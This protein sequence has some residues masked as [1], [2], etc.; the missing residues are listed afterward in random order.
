MRK[1]TGTFFALFFATGFLVAQNAVVKG[2]VVDSNSS[3][4]VP[5]VTITIQASIY[6][7]MTDA[8]GL[9][10]IES[11]EL[12]QGEQVLLVRKEGY[13]SQRIPITIQ[14]G[15]TLNLDPILLEIDLTDIEAQIGVISLSDNELSDDDGT[16]FNVS[17]LLQ[18]SR[19]AFLN[20]ASFDFSA[21]FF[22]PRGLDN[23][24]G[25]VLING[26]EM[27][28]QFTGR[29]QWGNWG[30]LNDVQRN[31]EFSMGL[32]AND[33]TFGDVAGTT[34]IVMRASQYRQGGRV[35]YAS[36]NRSYRGRIIGTY[37]SGLMQNGWAYSFSVARR[38]GDEGYQEGTVYDANSFFASV[39][40]KINDEHSLNF[41]AF[42][43]PNRRGRSTAIT[44]EQ[45]DLKG[46]QYNP[47][48]G[49][50]DGEIRN[51]RIREIE[52]P[53]FMLNHYWTLNEK[54]SLNTNIGYQTGTI[55]NSRIDN[56][57]TRL[58]STLD[59]Q[60]F[61][62]GGARNISGNYYQRL[63]SYFLRF[64]NPTSYNYQQAYLARE[65]FVAD[66]QIPWNTIYDANIDNDGNARNS[67]YI[68]QN[69]V[70]K[71]NQFQFNSILFS[72]ISENI[73]LNA[74]VAF[75]NL[76]SENYAEVSDLLGGNGY[77]DIDTFS[78]DASG[79][80]SATTTDDSFVQ[81]DV[82]NPNRIVGVGDRYKYNFELDATT[83]SG[84]AQAQF[85]YSL[86]DFYA[87]VN[88]G[89]TSYQRNGLY[90]NGNFQGNNRS[91]GESEKLDFTNYGI[92]GGATYKVTGRHLIDINA[93]YLTKAPSIRNSFS[94][95]RQN[96]DVVRN[97]E[98]EKIQN[99]DLSYIFRSP[100]VKARLTGFYNKV[101]D[102]TDI[103]FYFTESVR[104]AD[105]DGTFV[106]E[107]LTG[108]ESRRAGAEFGIEAQVTP[109]IKLKGAASMAQ[110]VYTNNPD[111]YFTSDDFDAFR[112]LG[113][114]TT[115]LKNIHVAGGPE[116]AYQLGFEYRDPDFWWV[117]VT[118]NYF[119]NAYVDVSSL[120]RNDNF[121]T[122]VDGQIFNDYDP[123]VA[124]DLL[125]QEQ[126]D[127]YSLVNVVGGKSWKIDDYYVGFFAT[128]N[129]VFDTRYRTGGFEDS[130]VGDYRGLVEESN[131]ET[132]VFSN[133]YFYGYGTTYYLN[134]YV[135]F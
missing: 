124:Q 106:Q 87:A 74:N 33:Y 52:E 89:T 53:V 88:G 6:E 11:M 104:N 8:K 12:P 85:K 77:L 122:D 57:G 103:N 129:N 100:I 5:D 23:A 18:A 75:R 25:K 9:F 48:W 20:A 131:R 70:N 82:R 96:N 133:R 22:R 107:V 92:K 63:P 17:G 113:D 69:D 41:T 7:A 134:L 46:I 47:N 97:L 44:E 15:K 55:K 73:A 24:N 116:N 19:D 45:R 43:T 111:Q 16:S 49:Y 14:N 112:E 86:V 110:Y 101:N 34:N 66:G 29:P 13:N 130:R 40:K 58:L 78:Q 135:R 108:I 102:Q 3:D 128:I 99:L 10:N 68:L 65:E 76:K 121:A 109:T 95:S 64:D 42:Y 119:S 35:S 80:G 81:S 125:Q 39:E 98:T 4:V 31:R 54:T 27:N 2:R 61:Y 1:F 79:D 93:G 123:E 132:A 72:Q 105:G 56:N 59:G 38:Y 127:S 91:F 94:N 36:S 67:T 32:T 37:N 120:R 60:N 118:G 28:K 51:S 30:G 115:N 21:T 90:E 83:I 117:G 126:L 71:D 50:Q 84:F 62:S 26:L 114:G